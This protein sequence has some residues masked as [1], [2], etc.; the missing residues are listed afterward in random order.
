MHLP[1]PLTTLLGPLLVAVFG[2]QLTGVQVDGR[3]V[4]RGSGSGERPSA[5]SSKASTSTQRCLRAQH[6]LLPRKIR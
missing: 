5:A 4:G 2:Q 3:P 1:E 6:K